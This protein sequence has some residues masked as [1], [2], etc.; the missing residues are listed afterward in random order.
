[1]YETPR[2]I[3]R[4]QDLLDR[5]YAS[6]G[7]HVLRVHNPKWRVSAAQ[8]CELL[9]G[10]CLLT[11]A[12]VN[13]RGAP[14]VAPMDGQFYR[15]RFY[16]GGTRDSSRAANIRARPDVSAAHV[17]GE[18]LGV[19]VHGTA[20]EVDKGAKKAEGYRKLLVEIYGKQMADENWEGDMVVYW[21][22]EP[23]KMFAVSFPS[24]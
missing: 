24:G 1:V 9:Q 13:A 12:T 11:L 15:G 2:D 21:E 10:M 20:R 23:R 7:P 3:T 18:S 22:I 6:A 5:S 17:Q 19:T 16:F 8:L 4:L 14:V